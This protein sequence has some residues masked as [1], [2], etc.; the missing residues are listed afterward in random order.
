M[1]NSPSCVHVLHKTL[2]VVISRCCFVEDG[3]ETYQNVKRT[4]RAF[5]FLIKPIVLRRCRC[6]RL[7]RSLQSR[8]IW[9]YD[10]GHKGY[11]CS[12]P[13]SWMIKLKECWGEAKKDS[14]GED[15]GLKKEEGE[16][17]RRGKNTSPNS[18]RIQNGGLLT[19]PKTPALQATFV[20]A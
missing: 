16:G 9:G 14:E 18:L 17:E 15:D 11:E 3:K 1:K 12:M 20:V 6:R 5:F 2:N 4:C 8:R 13:P 10:K 7:R 19:R